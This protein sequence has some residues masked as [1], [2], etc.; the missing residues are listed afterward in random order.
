M[1]FSAA[2]S[3]VFAFHVHWHLH[4][5]DNERPDVT[6]RR[7]RSAL[8]PCR[9]TGTL[10]SISVTSRLAIDG[11]SETYAAALQPPPA[12]PPTTRSGGRPSAGCL[13]YLEP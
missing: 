9:S 13:K 5:P 6:R 1:D 7:G 10:L 11:L 12:P 3:A 4:I 8:P 2:A